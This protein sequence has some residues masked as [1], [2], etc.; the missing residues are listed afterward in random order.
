M[1]CS[2]VLFLRILIWLTVG[3]QASTANPICKASYGFHIDPDHCIEA[4]RGLQPLL[5]NLGGPNVF[6]RQT[7]LATKPYHMPQAFA[8]RTCSIG[9]DI[10]DPVPPDEIVTSNWGTISDHIVQVI[11]GCV[12][13]HGIGGRL[14]AGGF[15]IVIVNQAAGLSYGTCLATHRTLNVSL[16]SCIDSRATKRERN[17]TPAS[18][19][20]PSTPQYFRNIAQPHP[21]IGQSLLPDPRMVHNRVQIPPLSPLGMFVINPRDAERSSA[22]GGLRGESRGTA[23][24]EQLQQRIPIPRP[25]PP[26]PNAGGPQLPRPVQ[27]WFGLPPRGRPPLE[28]PPRPPISDNRAQTWPIHPPAT[29]NAQASEVTSHSS[30]PRLSAPVPIPRPA[31]PRRPYNP[32]R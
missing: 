1:A 22:G 31:R 25:P 23:L 26:H 14:Q 32:I 13:P 2:L 21:G 15:D 4:L 11:Y 20:Q 6:S 10:A 17:P 12:Q 19:R 7:H 29:G 3:L 27:Q 18:N 16:G 8:W 24:N 9:V 28:R 30:R 5:E